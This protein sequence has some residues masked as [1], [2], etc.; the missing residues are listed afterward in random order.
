MSIFEELTAIIG[1]LDIPVETGIFS[2]K[3]PDTYIVL[4]PI[5]DSYD[6]FADDAPQAEVQ[7][8]RISI[9]AKA[10]YLEVKNSIASAVLSAGFTITMRRHIGH[11]DDTGY[12]HHA[13]DVAKEYSLQEEE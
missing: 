2:G 4:T 7:E 13:T 11:E 8:V 5:A 3:A 1:A 6:C 10:N 12:Y 9:Y